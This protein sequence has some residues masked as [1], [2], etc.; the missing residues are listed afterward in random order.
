[1]LTR[2]V[3]WSESLS[4]KVSIIIRRYIDQMK[5][6]AYTAVS[7]ITFF[8]IILG[9][10]CVIVNMVVFCMLLSNFVNY[11]FVL[12]CI[13]IVMY[14]LFWVFCFIV[15]FCVNVYCNTATGCQPNCS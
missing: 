13:L 5:F 4:N 8:H 3:K 2:V 11:V 15:L 12:L 14:V 9:L 6:S 1:M 10:F 7:F